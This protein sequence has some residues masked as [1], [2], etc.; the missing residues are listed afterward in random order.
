MDAACV[1]NTSGLKPNIPCPE[2]ISVQLAAIS[3]PLTALVEH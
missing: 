1:E 2:T 3:V